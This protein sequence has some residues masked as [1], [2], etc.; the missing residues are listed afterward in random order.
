MECLQVRLLEWG[1]GCREAGPEGSGH[2]QGREM[3]LLDTVL[4]HKPWLSLNHMGHQQDARN[5]WLSQKPTATLEVAE[6]RSRFGGGE[7]PPHT[8]EP[9]SPS[10]QLPG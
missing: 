4:A 6:Q 9:G 3:S 1:R 2:H 5:C 8:A 7:K 10:P